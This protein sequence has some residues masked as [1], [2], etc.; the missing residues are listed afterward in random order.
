VTEQ[1]APEPIVPPVIPPAP[2]AVPPVPEPPKDPP[3][4]KPEDDA[5][6]AELA[7]LKKELK[8]FKD[9]EKL[10]ADANKTAEEKAAELKLELATAKRDALVERVRRTHGFADK[11]YDV[12][13]A[14]GETEDEIKAAYEGH[15]TALDE[16]VKAQGVKSAPGAGTGGAPPPD[17]K[18]PVA[19]NRPYLIKMGIV[20]PKQAV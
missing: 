12:V 10:A 11:V 20:K 3:A 13:A 19:D 16:Y 7:N 4:P 6:K 5:A 8:A 2:P 1:E 18:N 14:V 9:K 17:P 15:K